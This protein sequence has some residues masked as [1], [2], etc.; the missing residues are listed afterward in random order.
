M[1]D[2]QEEQK[3]KENQLNLKAEQEL[4]RQQ[5]LFL[6]ERYRF[7]HIDYEGANLYS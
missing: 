4:D 6:T 2:Y 7:L 5:K 3:E 1:H